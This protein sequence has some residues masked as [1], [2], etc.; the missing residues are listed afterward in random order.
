MKKLLR[1]VVLGL[2]FSGNGHSAEKTYLICKEIN[3]T[4][5]DT[6]SF[7]N[8]FVYSGAAKYKILSNTDS[9]YA[10]FENDPDKEWG[11][12]RIDRITGSLERAHGLILPGEDKKGVIMLKKN[13]IFEIFYNCEKTEKKF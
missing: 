5:I 8:K 6:Y 3:K 12:I 10:S 2:L 1:I 11:F 13:M 7:D 4:K 9:V